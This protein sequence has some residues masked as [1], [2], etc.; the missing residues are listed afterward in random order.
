MDKNSI[1]VEVAFAKAN[2]QAVIAVSIVKESSIDEA[3]KKSGIVQRF[4]EIDLA[5]M[6]I[7]IFGKVCSLDKKL[8]QGDRIEIYRSLFQNPMEARRNRVSK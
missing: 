3:I 2:E 7:G 8:E 5:K 1:E 4:P 6:A